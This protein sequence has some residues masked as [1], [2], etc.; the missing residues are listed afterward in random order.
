MRIVIW[1]DDKENREFNIRKELRGLKPRL[2]MCGWSFKKMLKYIKEA[3]YWMEIKPE[4]VDFIEIVN[5]KEH[6][7]QPIRKK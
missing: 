3:L 7:L 4:Q 1:Y 2:Y 6:W 5:E